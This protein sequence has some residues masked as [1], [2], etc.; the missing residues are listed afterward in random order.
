MSKSKIALITAAVLTTVGI[1]GAIVTGIKVVPTTLSSMIKDIKEDIYVETEVKSLAENIEKLNINSWENDKLEIRKSNDNN[2]RIKTYKINKSYYDI[3]DNYIESDKTLTLNIKRN[4]SFHNIDN[5]EEQFRRMYPNFIGYDIDENLIVIEVPNQV[6]IN[7]E[8]N[9]GV[10]LDIKDDG[11]LKDDLKIKDTE[12]RIYSTFNIP[13]NNSLKNFEIINDSLVNLEVLDFIN[14]ENVEIQGKHINIKS[15][16]IPND[17]DLNNIPEKVSVRGSY[18]SIDSYIPLGKDVDI[19][20]KE[21]LKYIANFEDYNYIGKI[22][23][24]AFRNN[25]KANHD[26]DYYNREQNVDEYHTEN[27]N[28]LRL[29]NVSFDLN[30]GQYSG[31]LSQAEGEQYDLNITVLERGEIVNDSKINIKNNILMNR[32]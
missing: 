10:S 26:K 12:S 17:Y 24:K 20:S 6:D 5:I 9:S 11:I 32:R 31:K 16:D 2:T 25:D 28:I 18:I 14:A 21:E 4:R 3:E 23:S 13:N 15:K 7:I 29:E 8:G 27:N 19:Y 30:N 22:D 1:V